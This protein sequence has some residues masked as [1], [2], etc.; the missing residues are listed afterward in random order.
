MAEGTLLNTVS[1]LTVSVENVSRCDEE[2]EK[3]SS[4]E[5]EASSPNA[6]PTIRSSCLIFIIISTQEHLILLH[7][8]TQVQRINKSSHHER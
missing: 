6:I 2:L 4:S 7:E 5:H 3:L 1:S 8:K